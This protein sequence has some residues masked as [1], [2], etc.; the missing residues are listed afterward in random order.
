[1]SRKIIFFAVAAG[2]L[3]KRLKKWQS[4]TKNVCN[5]VNLYQWPLVV[6]KHTILY[7]IYFAVF[8]ILPGNVL[9]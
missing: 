9:Q 5:A 8:D 2:E 1:M 7:K 3:Q 4:I 6:T